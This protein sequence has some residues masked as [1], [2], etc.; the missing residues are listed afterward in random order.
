MLTGLLWSDRADVQ[1]RASLRQTLWTLRKALHGIEADPLCTTGDSVL[2]DASAVAVDVGQFESLVSKGTLEALLA[3]A[4]LYRGDLLQ[5]VR[6]RDRGFEAFVV[7][8]RERLHAIA[9]TVLKRLLESPALDDRPQQAIEMAHRLIALDPFEEA[10][11]RV[12]MAHWARQGRKDLALGQYRAC[13]SLLDR[14][15]GTAPQ[16]ETERLAAEIGNGRILR[17][18]HSRPT[19]RGPPVPRRSVL[20]A[21]A[22]LA[23]V[24]V[25]FAGV[26]VAY[27]LPAKG[28]NDGAVPGPAPPVPPALLVLPISGLHDGFA[29]TALVGDLTDDLALDLSRVV[30]H[31]VITPKPLA[32]ATDRLPDA[33]YLLRGSVSTALD[34]VRFNFQLID[35]WSGQ[36]LWADRYGGTASDAV[37]VQAAAR[38][39]LVAAVPMLIGA[40]HK[41]RLGTRD[42]VAAVDFAKGWQ[43]YLRHRPE[44]YQAA[45]SLF[46]RAIARDRQF[47]RANAALAAVYWQCWLDR[48]HEE[49]HLDSRFSAWDE[50]DAFL[51]LAQ[52][53]PTAIVH[54]VASSMLLEQGRHEQAVSEAEA[55][56]ALDPNDS[57]S[58][59]ALARAL[60]LSGRP[61]SA[62]KE[63]ARAEELNPLPTAL[64]L[65]AL[66]EAYHGMGRFTD[67]IQ[68]LKRASEANPYD[69]GSLA[70]LTAA[71]GQLGRFREASSA[72]S[73]LTALLHRGHSVTKTY[74]IHHAEFEISFR[75]ASDQGRFLDGLRKAGLPR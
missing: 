9:Q 36:T 56:V 64:H 14:E 21:V 72:H 27:F 69:R 74:S 65:R 60:A 2:L 8:E 35:Q 57:E 59:V 45:V 10:A 18:T 48:C 24:L 6:S 66:G 42:P 49:L 73:R 41:A 28:P 52:A 32:A 55:A 1:A 31:P 46:Q 37:A 22:G 63:L 50:A 7:P 26:A 70:L 67:A 68:A 47:G 3:A 13:A 20:Q 61:A 15:L 75:L 39:G 54:Q 16:P 44:A 5:G 23:V 25:V 30:R 71:Y 19:L 12:L 33:G 58:F 40:H 17:S 53:S 34:R 38:A 4:A 29:G 62:F 51:H 11:H 43:Q